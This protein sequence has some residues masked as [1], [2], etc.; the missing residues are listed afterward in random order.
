MLLA[1]LSTV[2]TRLGIT[3]TTDDTLLTNHIEFASARFERETNRARSNALSAPPKNSPP[4]KP[5]SQSPV[6]RSSPSL[7]ST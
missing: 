5:K 7:S 6:S 4:T 1:Q 3:D 2:K